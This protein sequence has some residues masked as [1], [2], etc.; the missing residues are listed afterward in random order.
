MVI[1]FSFDDGRQDNY[2]IAFPIMKQYDLQATL[3]VVTGYIDGTWSPPK[4]TWR[5]AKG[6]LT[7]LELK[8]MQ[9]YG[10][11]IAFHGD[12]HKMLPSDYNIGFNKLKSWELLKNNTIGFSAPNSNLENKKDFINH[13]KK[14]CSYLR[15]GR[16]PAS[17]TLCR[18]ALFAL[19]RLTGSEYFYYNFNKVN[20][21]DPKN[22]NP[23]ELYSI[24]IRR[25]D[26]AATIVKFLKRFIG[27]NTW[28]IFMLHSI[29]DNT[30][31]YKEADPWCWDKNEF[32][33][34][35][36]SVSALKRDGS[37]EVKSI[38]EVIQS[39]K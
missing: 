33:E 28:V 3:H 11:E 32:I 26:R 13:V 6:P 29:Q 24:V 5:S 17:Y 38:S 37:M 20:C 12:K 23:F 22:V 36:A 39:L 2:K 8:E 7:L 35:C 34:F 19:Y 15:V 1:S 27:S 18:K 16:S 31:Q 30:E 25:E 9:D 14:Q 4:E 10:F 21:L